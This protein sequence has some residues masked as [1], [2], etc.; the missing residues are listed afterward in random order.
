MV[1]ENSLLDLAQA[2]QEVTIKHQL[3]DIN[4]SV[5]N[6]INFNNHLRSYPGF[7]AGLSV[8]LWKQAYKSNT[9]AASKEIEIRQNEIE[10]NKNDLIQYQNRLTSQL[11]MHRQAIDKYT[12][13]IQPLQGAVIQ[14]AEKSFQQ[15]EIDFFQYI[16]TLEN[17]TDMKMNYLYHVY[18]YNQTV[19][20][21]NFLINPN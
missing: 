7:T 16:L 4:L 5:F 17:N 13:Q 15:G 20:E 2:A 1:Y 19:I 9:L 8:P 3:P 11:A 12:Q 6:G 21:L 18:K 10:K 14:S